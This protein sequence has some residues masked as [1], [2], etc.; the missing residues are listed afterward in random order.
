[1]IAKESTSRILRDPHAPSRFSQGSVGKPGAAERRKTRRRFTPARLQIAVRR[2]LDSATRSASHRL[3]R[4]VQV[5][6]TSSA[7]KT[8]RRASPP[9]ETHRQLHEA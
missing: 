8:P 2:D 4:H 9:G 3:Q 7:G 6:P 1:M 5:S